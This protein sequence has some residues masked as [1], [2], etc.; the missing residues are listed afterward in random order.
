MILF[1]LHIP[2]SF[3]HLLYF[4]LFNFLS[5]HHYLFSN[6]LVD[7][8]YSSLYN[9]T[10][11][12]IS[13]LFCR[14]FSIELYFWVSPLLLYCLDYLINLDWLS[15]GSHFYN[16]P[17]KMLEITTLSEKLKCLKIFFYSLIWLDTEFLFFQDFFFLLS[18]GWESIPDT[19][20]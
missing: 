1:L 10:F 8:W 12:S 18:S 15:N 14:N 11:F 6:S 16:S 9:D 13:I 2:L 20:Y 4:C 5:A 3:W 7:T 17:R 19:F